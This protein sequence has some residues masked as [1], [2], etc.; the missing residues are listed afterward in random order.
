MIC[1][2]Y[3][4]Y[5]AYNTMPLIMYTLYS[6][7]SNRASSKRSLALVLAV[8][9]DP[10]FRSFSKGS[11]SCDRVLTN[12]SP[13]SSM[14]WTLSNSSKYISVIWYRIELGILGFF[15]LHINKWNKDHYLKGPDS[16]ISLYCLTASSDQSLPWR[17]RK[18]APTYLLAR[19]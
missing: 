1:S 8:L 11:I 2:G 3:R 14:D 12:S 18:P 9:S 6:P 4:P 19:R 17:N 15:G 13:A 10:S 5:Y 16:N 7:W